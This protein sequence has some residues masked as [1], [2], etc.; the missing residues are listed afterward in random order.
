M[1]PGGKSAAGWRRKAARVG[2]I[3]PKT[4][5]HPAVRAWAAGRSRAAQAPWAVAFSG[6]ADSLALLLAIWAH[7]PE[8]RARLVPLHFNHQLRGRAAGADERFCRDVCRALGLRARVGRWRRRRGTV[9]E[10]EARTAR[11]AFFDRAMQAAGA[12]ALWLGHQQDDVAEAMLMRLARGSGAAGLAAP[13]PVQSVGR[14]LHLRPLLTQ[15]KAAIVAALR[16]ARVVWRED[17][18]NAAGRYFRNRVR[19]EVVPAWVKAA[20][21]DAVAG[22]ACARELLEEDDDALECWLDALRPFGPRG[23]TL[24]VAALT[25]RPRALRR[26]ALR[27]WLASQPLAP[28]ISRQGFEDLLGAVATGRNARRSLGTRGFAVVRNGLLRF[29]RTP[30]PRSSRQK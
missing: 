18:T 1:T 14:R 10:E 19:N 11:F 26:R 4:S 25:G 16:A 17:R 9:S 20:G 12:R 28:W 24:N 27:R 21:R 13:R 8:R 23:T 7:W 2:A 3:L 22:A 6:G 30:V 15:K 29:A 5:L